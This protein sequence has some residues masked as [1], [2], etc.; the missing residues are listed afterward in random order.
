[1]AAAINDDKL[2]TEELEK[3]YSNPS[4]LAS[5]EGIDS[6]YREAKA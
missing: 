4:S 5:F 6:I 3:I 2:L 1:M